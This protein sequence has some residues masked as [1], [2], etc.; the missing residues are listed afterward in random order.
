[1]TDMPRQKITVE[2]FHQLSESNQIIELIDGEIVVSPTPTDDHQHAVSN[3]HILLVHLNLGGV[4]RFA[5]L[6]VYLDPETIV[7]P[8]LFW[9]APD[10]TRC[11][12]GEDGYWH[13]SPDLIIEILSPSNRS[14]DRKRKF[15]LYEQFGVR[16]YWIADPLDRN[17]EVWLLREDKFIRAGLFEP[18][19]TFTSPLLNKTIDLNLIFN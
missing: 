16:E 3:L 5:P 1:M 10:N 11:V 7:E 14:H 4:L 15:Y 13:G 2:Q 8:D 9:I 12:K 17:L 18:G 6:Q 19:E